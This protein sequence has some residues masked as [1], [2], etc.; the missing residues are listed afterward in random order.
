MTTTT[1]MRIIVVLPG[2]LTSSLRYYTPIPHSNG[3]ARTP[4]RPRPDRART[5]EEGMPI[6]SGIMFLMYDPSP[7]TCT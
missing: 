3:N 7:L 1:A 2:I 4:R 6:S 5:A